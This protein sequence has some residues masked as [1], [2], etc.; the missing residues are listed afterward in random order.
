M[1]FIL[2][3]GALINLF[4]LIWILSVLGE[5]RKETRQTRQVLSFINSAAL[6]E[7]L[8]RAEDTLA[9][10]TANKNDKRLAKKQIY[11]LEQLISL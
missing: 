8:E 1:E 9:S 10:D 4:I 7:K 6:L 3:I 2:G 5:I 11:V